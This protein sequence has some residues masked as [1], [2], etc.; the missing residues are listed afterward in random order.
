[1]IKSEK[2]YIEKYGDIP[3][4]HDGRL[5]YLL[6]NLKC[7]R[8]KESFYSTIDNIKSIQ[9]KK[10]EYIIYIVPKGT[11]RPRAGKF[12]V[13][14]VK[15][16]KDNKKL[17]KQFMDM[18]KDIPLITTAVKLDCSSYLPIPSSMNWVEK[19]L[20]EL[21]LIRP[22]TTP[23]FDNLVKT[24]T[25]MMKDS[26]LYDDSLIIEGTSRKYYSVKPRVEITLWYADKY[27]CKFN[28]SKIN[29]KG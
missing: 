18:Q 10:L 29:K 23:D 3:K 4:D 1:M 24:Y 8:V 14:Y 25:D 19:V 2:E 15:G 13:F 22:I 20:S 7:G 16:A 21:G 28:Q 11:P 26:L 17:F 6:S 27:D 9:W 12:G 5:D